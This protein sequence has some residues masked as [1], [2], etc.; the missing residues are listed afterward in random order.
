MKTYVKDMTVGNPTGL[1]LS[2]MLPM[3]IGNI[4]QQFYSMVDS[5]IVGQ[6]V[7]AD[8]LAAVGATSSLNFLFFSLCG[9]MS[10]GIGIV[11]SQQ[12][13]AGR[14]EG[15]KKAI[16][17]AAY[18]MLTVGIA[19]GL[20]GILLSRPILSFL[21]TP[22]NILDQAT[23]Y[24]QITCAGVLAVALYNCV[25]AIL[26]AVGDSKTPLYFL[27]VASV[28]NVF[29]DLLFVRVFHM[30]VAGAA[31]ATIIA[32]L[33]SGI[34]SLIFAM[35][36]NP[37]FKIEKEHKKVDVDII[38]QS[39]RMGIPLAFQSSLIAIS[40]VALQSVVNGFGS[41]VVA[42]FTATSRIEQLIQQPYNSLGMAVSTFAG[43]NIGAGK[44]DRVKKGYWT[45]WKIMAIFSLIMMP[46][47]M[48]GGEWIMKLFVDEVEVIQL[49][50]QALKM[51]SWF[52]LFLGTIY[53]TRGMLNGVGDASF[54]FING[55]IEVLG[56]ICFA[57]P[58][59]LIPVIGVW[60]VWLATAF[61]WCIT[62]IVSMTRYFQGKWRKP[63]ANR[64][65]ANAEK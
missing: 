3:V 25:S 62:G 27:I 41:V 63:L 31:V 52:Y 6:Y 8:A 33:I 24:M 28:L 21:N 1:L 4:F 44:E 9:G 37:Y 64:N 32:Q 26:R 49:G 2:F 39:A 12:F 58:L 29:M 11:I 38:R 45:G 50:S 34:G 60:G 35:K 20:L 15:V 56:R 57:K 54:A 7:G 51:T 14:D 65:T 61:T 59:T 48:F 19:M 23:L 5:I 53:V 13:G 17:N 36:K 43:Q 18:I 42:A 10:N 55:I 46:T 47:M 16:A 30:G 22:E 40:C